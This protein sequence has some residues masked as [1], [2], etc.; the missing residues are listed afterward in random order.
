MKLGWINRVRSTSSQDKD[1]KG[2]TMTRQSQLHLGVGIAFAGAVLL[3][4][5]CATKGY[6]NDR[7]D[8]VRQEDRQQHEELTARTSR[9]ENSTED[10]LARAQTAL[11]AAEQVRDL[12]LGKA[13]LEELQRYT[14]RFGFDR[15]NLNTDATATLDQASSLLQEHPEA[16]VD[17]YGFADPTGPDRYNLDLGQRRAEEV[18]RYLVATTPGRLSQYAA[19]S[20]GEREYG[21]LEPMGTSMNAASRRVVVSVIRRIPLNEAPAAAE[22]ISPWNPGDSNPPAGN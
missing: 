22:A 9:L 11:D 4:Q 20:Y 8:E 21:G 7:L 12:A 17:V 1:R 13:G 2:E 19:V 15:D 10:A 16:I 14:I 5:G 6:V 18:V 3:L